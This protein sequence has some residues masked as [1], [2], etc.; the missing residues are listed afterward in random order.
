LEINTLFS[1]T[2][3][4]PVDVEGRTTLPDFVLRVLNRRRSGCQILFG[5][6]EADPCTNGFDEDHGKTLHAEV[7]RR[8]LVEEG[9]GAS[10][11]LHHSRVRRT[12]G[13]VE[14]A[15]V[16]SSGRVKLPPMMRRRSRIQAAVLF[17]GTG[18]RFEVWN[19]DLARTAADE[20]VRELAEFALSQ[21]ASD[22][23]SEVV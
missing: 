8:R 1:G 20:V 11:T 22:Q 15:S 17:I 9:E 3:L 19:P 2:S 12:F 18:A 6:H 14:R 13:A 23:E 5:A 21:Q 16:D 4:E 7:E 10:A